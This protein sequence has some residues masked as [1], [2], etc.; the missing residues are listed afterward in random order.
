ML[1]VKVIKMLVVVV[2]VFSLSWLPLYLIFT[3]IKLGG[4]ISQWEDLVLSIATPIAQ[5]LGASNS[6]INPILYAYFNQKYRRAFAA[7]I[8]SR[9][10][11]SSIRLEDDRSL[12]RSVM[13]NHRTGTQ[14]CQRQVSTVS[15]IDGATQVFR[16]S[17]HMANSSTHRGVTSH[18]IPLTVIDRS[19]I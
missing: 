6:C 3:R 4:E 8:K 11:C 13:D 17:K 19:M 16:N 7:I 9:S 5:W 2:V 14:R 18:E 1:K 15:H 12:Y 10:C